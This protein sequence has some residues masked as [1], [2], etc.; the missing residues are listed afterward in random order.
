MR[1]RNTLRDIKNLKRNTGVGKDM[2]SGWRFHLDSPDTFSP[3]DIA[4]IRA[5]GFK[6]RQV[7]TF[8]ELEDEVAYDLYLSALKANGEEHPANL[9]HKPWELDALLPI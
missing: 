1:N 4:S 2:I 9:D 7:S 5:A 3:F 8:I 6:C